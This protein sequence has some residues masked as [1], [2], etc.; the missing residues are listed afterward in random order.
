MVGGVFVDFVEVVDPAVEE[1]GGA[2]ML[3]GRGVRSV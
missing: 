1:V 2:E 3:W